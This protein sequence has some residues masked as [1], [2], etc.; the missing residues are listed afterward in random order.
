M[1]IGLSFSYMFEDKDWIKKILIGGLISLIPIVN[2]AALGYVVQLVRN[3]RD[4]RPLPL[5]EWD[6]FGEYF[7]SGLWL[8]LIF[9]VYSIPIIILACLQGIGTAVIGS[10]SGG[11]S[12][13]ADSAASVYVIV[14]TCL[15][16]LMG[17]W[18]L[19]L[20]V[21]SPAIIV[22]FAET[23]QFGASLR[24][25]GWLDVIKA[26]VGGYLIVMIL[27]WVASGIIAPL[28][29]ILCVV[30]VIFTQFWAYL[31]WGNLLGQLAGEV[32]RVNPMAA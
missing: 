19:V 12:S 10:A 7:M 6:Q 26:N 11:S 20:G 18:G 31:V 9:L 23:G 17:L 4:G 1:D 21:I 25:A 22:R 29:L 15:S 27:M 16:C 28:G 30:G 14:S 8:F 32:R 24:F 2:F 13:T 3:T 5:P